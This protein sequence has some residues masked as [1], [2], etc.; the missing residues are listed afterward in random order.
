MMAHNLCYT[1]LLDKTTIER[2]NLQEGR[3][4]VKTP[5]NGKPRLRLGTLIYSRAD[6][7]FC[8]QISLRLQI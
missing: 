8:L 7:S 6:G 4:Y 1:T 3:D 5:N 2:M